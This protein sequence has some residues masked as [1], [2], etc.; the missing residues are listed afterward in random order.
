MYKTRCKQ[1]EMLSVGSSLPPSVVHLLITSSLNLM[2]VYSIW[3]I[4]L[5]RATRLAQLHLRSRYFAASNTTIKFK[6]TGYSFAY[7]MH[8]IYQ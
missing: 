4:A 5:R 8:I 1:N 3:R 2:V 6:G 7:R